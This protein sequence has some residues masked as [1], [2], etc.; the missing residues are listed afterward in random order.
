MTRKTIEQQVTKAV[1]RQPVTD[2]HTHCYSP[3]FGA[4]PE[5][6][7]LMLW[8]IDDLLTY[9]YLVA[10]V[11]RAVPPSELPYDAFWAMGKSEQADHIWQHLFVARTPLSEACRGVL[12]VLD[13]LGLDPNARTLK[14]IRKWFSQQD[15]DDFVDQVMRI[16]N[17]D[18]ITMT[19]EVF[20]DGERALWERDPSIGDDPRF[21]AVL[22]LDA[23]LV[24]WARACGKLQSW[25]YAAK[26][27]FSGDTAAQ[28]RRFLDEWLDRIKA[29]Y[30]A[31]SLPPE[32]RYP[33]PAAPVSERFIREVFLPVLAERKMPWAMMIGVWRGINPPLHEAAD[34]GGPAD[35]VS[36]INLCRDFPNNK[37][38]VTMLA[39]ENQHQLCQAARKFANLM[40]FGCWWFLN[41]PSLIDEL[42]RM[43]LELLGGSFVPQHSDARILDQLIY[44][45]EHSRQVIASVLT[46]KYVD[47][48][49]SGFHVTRQHIQKDAAL[50]LRDNYRDFLTR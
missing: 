3:R 5:P 39:R 21:A 8:G 1:Y 25:G 26:P 42:T 15:P 14:P 37:F 27:D 6:G 31:T 34:M 46:D 30:V 2:L 12:T 13:K 38:M 33:N 4:S 22:R 19:N 47:L 40:P 17:V 11:F 35:V 23:L 36:L 29:Q 50:L 28:L 16:A 10:E 44:K 18:Q 48:E 32:F 20:H 49:K 43:R 41:N 45:W 9:H 24:D 7:G